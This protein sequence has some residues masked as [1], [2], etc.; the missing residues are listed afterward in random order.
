MK[1]QGKKR[2]H[3][4]QVGSKCRLAYDRILILHDHDH[5]HHQKE[6][7]NVVSCPWANC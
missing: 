6:N 3:Y 7:T 1:D 4:C 2:Q 5:H